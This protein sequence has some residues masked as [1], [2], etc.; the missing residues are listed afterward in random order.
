MLKILLTGNHSTNHLRINNMGDVGED[1]RAY[2]AWRKEKKKSNAEWSLA[3]LDECG[4]SYQ[5]KNYTHYIITHGG[6]T[7]DYYPSTGLWWDR[8]NK[9]QRR[10]IRQLLN[11]LG[12]DFKR[13]VK[14]ET[15]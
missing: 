2:Q 9:R 8:A 13:E 12:I 3:K 11:Y 4:I 15:V 6:K 1:F 10:G 7:L 14:N 5:T